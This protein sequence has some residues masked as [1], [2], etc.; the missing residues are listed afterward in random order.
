MGAWPSRVQDPTK[1]L[2][3][4]LVELR[5]GQGVWSMVGGLGYLD[6]LGWVERSTYISRWLRR[7]GVR[8]GTYFF[9][10]SDVIDIFL[11]NDWPDEEATRQYH[12]DISQ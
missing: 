3:D 5:I 2:V 8:I 4:F 9:F 10:L 1:G 7:F 12:N 6:G 11:E